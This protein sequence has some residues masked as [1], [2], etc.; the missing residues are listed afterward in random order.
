M[1]TNHDHSYPARRRRSRSMPNTK[2]I[3]AALRLWELKRR[4]REEVA[5]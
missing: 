3:M 2:L 1:K 4:T 5:R